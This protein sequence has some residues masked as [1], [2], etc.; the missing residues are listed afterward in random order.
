MDMR[1][2]RLVLLL[3]FL[4]IGMILIGVFGMAWQASHAAARPSIPTNLARAIA[5][6]RGWL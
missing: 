2:N 3:L 5:P 6:E 4:N 1:T